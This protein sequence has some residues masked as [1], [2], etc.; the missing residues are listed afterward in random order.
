MRSYDL[1][2]VVRT[3][4]KDADR[5]KLIE[6]IKGW[7]DDIKV[8]KEDDWGQRPLAYPIKKQDAGHYYLVQFE[9][10]KGIAKGSESRLLRNDDILRHLIL[11]T[12]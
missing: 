4:V 11:R 9:S 2:V 8:T 7:F 12:K 6:T 5:K 1:V 10:E 3:S